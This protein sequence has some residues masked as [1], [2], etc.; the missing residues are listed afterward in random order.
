METKK[1][2][3]AAPVVATSHDEVLAVE[4]ALHDNAALSG[5]AVLAGRP[6]DSILGAKEERWVKKLVMAKELAEGGLGESASLAV[7][8]LRM[9]ASLRTSGRF[10]EM[11]LTLHRSFAGALRGKSIVILREEF[12]V[13][14]DGPESYLAAAV[15]P[16][17]L[18]RLAVDWETN[19]PWGELADLDVMD[20]GGNPVGRADLG[21]PPRACLI[22]GEDAALCTTERRHGLASIEARIEEIA[23]RPELAERVERQERVGRPEWAAR[24]CGEADRRIG[25]L[26]LAAALYEASAAP[27]PGLVDPLSR[28]A[29]KDMDYLTFMSSAAA[30]GP[31]FAEFARLGR[32]HHGE[33]SGLLPALREAGKAAER[34]MFEATGGVNTHKGLIFSMGLLCA[35][36]GRLGAAGRAYEAQSC[37][38][39]AAEIARGITLRDFSGAASATVGERLFVAEG[40]RGI[41][42]E[43]EDGFLAV[44]GCA[45]PKL[46]AGLAAGLSWNDA[47]VGTLLELCCVV[48][49]TNV[50]GRAGR[51]G[52]AI[53]RS[54]AKNALRLGGMATPEGQA[55]VHA[56][57]GILIERNIS[58][59]GCADL[60]A[61]TVFLHLLTSSRPSTKA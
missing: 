20:S 19:H 3:A 40:I 57:D 39:T 17:A 7:I 13:G 41:R 25:S 35:A 14:G 23:A 15:D 26:A 11:A 61:V 54:E 8:T 6:A 51:N 53:L 47:M 52:L 27:K 24:D 50:L 30:I 4:A 45:L 9:P 10:G 37:A 42:G 21:F 56:M 48:E 60:L 34:D 44:I 22:C 5:K 49:D 59:G 12:R 55:A 28:G 16:V 46:E 29:H 18:K 32:L 38:A 2:K 1:A 58:P 31:W 33:L 43:A 36:A